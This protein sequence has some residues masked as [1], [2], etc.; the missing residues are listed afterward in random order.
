[1]G[2][3]ADRSSSQ[4]EQSRCWL[5]GRSKKTMVKYKQS[6]TDLPVAMRCGK[7]MGVKGGEKGVC[8][9]PDPGGV[10][11]GTMMLDL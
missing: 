11:T 8:N 1:M 4:V 2:G 10:K 9:W 7:Q 5:G 3:L 6:K